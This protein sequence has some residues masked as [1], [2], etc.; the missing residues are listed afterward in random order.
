MTSEW[1]GLA[2]G[3]QRPRTGRETPAV[4]VVSRARPANRQDRNCDGEPRDWFAPSSR[5]VDREIEFLLSDPFPEL[6]PRCARSQSPGFARVILEIISPSRPPAHE[7][8]FG[9]IDATTDR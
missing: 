3:M 7:T 2:H 1:R 4:E 9:D 8:S 5:P 6:V